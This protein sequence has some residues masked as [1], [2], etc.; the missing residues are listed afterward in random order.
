MMNINSADESL[1]NYSLTADFTDQSLP[2]ILEMLE[3]SLNLKYEIDDN[4]II[5]NN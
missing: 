1:L 4:Q 3:K 5:L 2:A